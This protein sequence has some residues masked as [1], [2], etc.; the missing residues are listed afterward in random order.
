VQ[1]SI[2]KRTTIERYIMARQTECL[3][4]D[5]N[6]WNWSR[7]NS[8][9]NYLNTWKA[10]V[11]KKVGLYLYSFSG[12]SWFTICRTLP[13]PSTAQWL[14]GKP[15]V[16]VITFLLHVFYGSQNEWLFAYTTLVASFL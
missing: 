1:V 16:S 10:E 11:K 12:P 13:L 8:C 3:W 9:W 14:L 7:E 5:N 2:Q 4:S 15:P 6:D